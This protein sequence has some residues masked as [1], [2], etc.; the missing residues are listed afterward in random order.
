MA[1][2]WVLD[3][4]TKGTGAHIAP[5]DERP[6]SPEKP[7]SLTRMA[8]PRPPRPNTAPE[9]RLPRR[10]KVVDVMAS[11]TILDDVEA[12]VALAALAVMDKAIDARVYVREAN[13]ERWRLLTLAETRTLWNAARD[14]AQRAREPL[15]S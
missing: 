10:F 3:T 4:E 15:A 9:P 11:H 12:P 1:R 6:R 2:T 8:D 13:S 14:S 5:L 7:L